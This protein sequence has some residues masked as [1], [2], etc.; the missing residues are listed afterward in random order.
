VA[1]F[2]NSLKDKNGNAIPVILRP[3]H[4]HNGSWLWWG[5]KHCSSEEYKKLYQQFVQYMG[6]KGVH[7]VLYAYSIDNFP[8]E[9]DYLERYQGD[10][11]VDILGFDTYHR[12]APESNEKF[13]SELDR[14]L[15]TLK[16][17]AQK[18]QKLFAITETCLEK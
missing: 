14:M 5:K 16:N 13:V 4:E 10:D 11:F 3:F 1:V 17:Y 12:N 15:T 2:L 7:N 9:A 8:D 18:H 6:N